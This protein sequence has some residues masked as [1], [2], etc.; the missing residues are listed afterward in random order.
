MWSETPC[1]CLCKDNVRRHS[2]SQL[3]EATDRELCRQQSGRDGGISNTGS[4]QQSS[5]KGCNGVFILACEVRN[6]THTS[7]YGLLV[8]AVEF[9]GCSRLHHFINSRLQ[10]RIFYNE[11]N[12]SKAEKPN[13]EQYFESLHACTNG[14]LTA[15]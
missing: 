9:I 3:K 6:A 8:R 10:N 12:Q 2:L 7:L 11:K 15:P 14:S 4:S 5:H 13:D 1:S